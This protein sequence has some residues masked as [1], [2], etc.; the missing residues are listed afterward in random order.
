M[1]FDKKITPSLESLAKKKV[2][3]EFN[4]SF[5]L[6]SISISDKKLR[7]FLCTDDLQDISL[8]PSTLRITDV[9]QTVSLTDAE[10]KNL[11]IALIIPGNSTNL[12]G[13]KG[14]K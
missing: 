2:D 9:L 14:I 4:S 12:Q 10:A 6:A 1:L 3:F 11:V 5:Y 8:L 7:I 13:K